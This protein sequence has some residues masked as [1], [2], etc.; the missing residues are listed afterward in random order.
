MPTRQ[1]IRRRDRW[2]DW[3]V[4]AL[5]AVALL[6]GL[7][8]REA[9]LSRTVPFDFPEAGISGRCPAKWVRET[10]DDPLLRARDP[11]GGECGTVLELRS[12]PLAAGVDPAVVLDVL[13]L[14]R[15]GQEA[16]YRTLGTDPVQLGERTLTRRRFTYVHV[17][18]G[19]FVNRR[20]A[21][22]QGMDLALREGDRIIVA[23]LLADEER[24]DADYRFL[25]AFIQSLEL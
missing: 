22:V 1:A 10:G 18:C 6:L 4:F 8:L 15:A 5:V 17:D 11:F 7:G 16:A 23:T 21:I 12:R 25:H 20:P 24:F 9:V 13:A 14:E 2:A 19:P 3:T